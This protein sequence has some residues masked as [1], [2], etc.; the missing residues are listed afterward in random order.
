MTEQR[1]ENL[2]IISC[3]RLITPRELKERLPVSERARQ[4]VIDGR[5]TIKRILERED[6]R[7][8]IVVGPCSCWL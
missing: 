4:S 1:I 7:L 8:F 5:E 6:K 2:N 3:T